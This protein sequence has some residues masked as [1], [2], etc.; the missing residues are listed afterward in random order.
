MADYPNANPSLATLV[1]NVDYPQADDINSVAREVEAIGAALLGTLAHDLTLATSK[2][3]IG[4][5]VKFPATQVASS[6]ANT[7]DDYEEGVWTPVLGGTGGQTGQ[8]YSVQVGAYIKIG[9]LVFVQGRVVL[10]T[11]GTITGTLR[12]SGLPFTSENTT[13]LYAAVSI[14]YWEN[15]SPGIVYLAGQISPNAAA[16]DLVSTDVATGTLGQPTTSNIGNTSGIIFS[17]CYRASA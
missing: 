10:S 1:D 11:K 8:A 14:G 9:K 4:E 7:L 13:N 16:V 12:I 2:K 17:G 3:F 15:F 5:A 6:D